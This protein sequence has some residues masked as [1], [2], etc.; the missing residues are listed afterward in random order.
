MIKDYD[1]LFDY[2]NKLINLIQPDKFD[3]YRTE[4]LKDFDVEVVP[5]SLSGHIPI[6][7]V[8]IGEET[9]KMGI[10]CG[11]E[12]NLIDQ[13]FFPKVKNKIAKK[14]K[15]HKVVQIIL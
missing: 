5:M 4:N 8:K 10:D 12:Y 9:L 6:I 1:V 13:S 2:E 15:P 7:E 11:A 3:A 14:E